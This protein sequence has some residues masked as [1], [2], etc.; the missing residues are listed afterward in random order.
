MP[1]LR[2]YVRESIHQARPQPRDS[3]QVVLEE[4]LLGR[5]CQLGTGRSRSEQAQ[6]VVVV[7]SG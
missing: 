4:P 5:F 6:V 1:V 7:V 2:S 3:V